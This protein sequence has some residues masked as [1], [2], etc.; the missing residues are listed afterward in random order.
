MFRFVF[1]FCFFNFFIV[2]QTRGKNGKISDRDLGRGV[3][4][5]L[6]GEEGYISASASTAQSIDFP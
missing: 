2:A 6:A 3:L 5:M 1:V 4:S